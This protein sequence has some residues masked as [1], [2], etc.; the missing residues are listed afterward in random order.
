MTTPRERALAAFSHA[1]PDRI[2][3]YVRKVHDWPRHAA[4]LG[5]TTLTELMD[6]LGNTIVSFA[7]SYLATEPP[8]LAEQFMPGM[9][10]IWGI[11]G[12]VE[13][14]TYSDALPRPL[15]HAATVADVDAYPWPSAKAEDWDLVGMR[16]ALSN[17]HL[18][19]RLSPS[20]NPVFSQ[21]CG[22]FGMEEAMVNLRWNRAV[23]EAAL[24]H[25][26][27]FYTTFYANML[28]AC[29]DQLELFGLGDDF[30]A[31]RGLLIRPDEWRKLLLPL[32]AKWL[33]IAKDRGLLTVMHCCG[34]IVDVLSDLIDSGLDAWQTV[35]THLPDQDPQTLKS[36]F[37]NHLTFVGAIDTTNVLGLGSPEQVR[38]HVNDQIHQLGRGGGY[39]CGPDHTILEDVP[40]ENVVALYWAIAGFRQPGY[41]LE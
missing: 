32:Y 25:L 15:A 41:T 26:D 29:G 11:A 9:P 20:W 38:R 13:P 18:H 30:A 12:D 40:T 28:D 17:D 21:L 39:I 6:H 23:I 35:Q 5:V 27:D 33:R 4:A 3:A 2:P 36:R 34:R 24:A 1:V 37:G 31:N 8:V 16:R 10:S 19:A 22:L 14:Y 7:P